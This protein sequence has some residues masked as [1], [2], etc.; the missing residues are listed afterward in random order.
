MLLDLFEISHDKV[1]CGVADSNPIQPQLPQTLSEQH[2][3][4]RNEATFTDTCPTLN[5]IHILLYVPRSIQ[6]GSVAITKDL[7]T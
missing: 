3:Q 2:R 1:R 5:P 7:V 4:D 6:K